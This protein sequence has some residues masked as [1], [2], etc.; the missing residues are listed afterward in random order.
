MRKGE[1]MEEIL[2]RIKEWFSK[3]DESSKDI[4]LMPWEVKEITDPKGEVIGLL[5]VNPRMPV[6]FLATPKEKTIRI[7]VSL[8]YKTA[9]LRGLDRLKAYRTALILN[10]R[11]ELA[12][13]A[14]RGDEDELVLYVDLDKSSLGED[15]FNDALSF[16]FAAVAAISEKLDL[17]AEISR[18]VME[19][20]IAMLQERI[21]KGMSRE[22]LLKFLTKRVGMSEEE[23]SQIVSVLTCSSGKGAESLYS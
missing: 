23:A 17:E 14:L 16:L 9:Y 21:N 8:G 7:A 20:L 11:L 2:E 18:Q 6:R 15:E 3:G 1:T 12:K 22:D 5:A 10:D 13:F 4:V 19:S